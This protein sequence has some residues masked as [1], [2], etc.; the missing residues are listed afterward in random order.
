MTI[1]DQD[2]VQYEKPVSSIGSILKNAGQQIYLHMKSEL[3]LK[4]SQRERRLALLQMQTLDDH[5]LQD[6]GVT[7]DDVNWAGNLPKNINAAKELEALRKRS[8]AN[9]N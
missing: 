2:S 4:K 9:R 3:L 1:I 6:I 8:N 5:I 7:R